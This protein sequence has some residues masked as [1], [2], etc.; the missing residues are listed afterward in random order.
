MVQVVVNNQNFTAF[1]FAADFRINI[2]DKIVSTP[3]FLSATFLGDIYYSLSFPYILYKLES[4]QTGKVKIFTRTSS[5]PAV[6]I[7][8]NTFERYITLSFFYSANPNSTENLSNAE[9]LV[10]TK[11]FPL[12]LYNITIYETDTLGELNP[13]NAKATLYNGLLNM[14]GSQ[15]VANNFEE[16]QYKEYTSN[17]TDNE[18]V[19]LTN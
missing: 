19:Y 15:S 18:N 1:A 12:G 5:F 11:E 8:V 4:Q 6:G 3:T 7:N 13:D 16:V 9:V 17:D 14:T 10:G 2:S